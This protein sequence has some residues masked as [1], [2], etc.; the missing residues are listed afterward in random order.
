MFVSVIMCVIVRVFVY[1]CVIVRMHVIL[2]VS[3]CVWASLCESSCAC[4][5]LCFI[6]GFTVRENETENKVYKW[7]THTHTMTHT[8]WNTHYDI[9]KITHINRQLIQHKRTS[10]DQNAKTH[11]LN[12]YLIKIWISYIQNNKKLNYPNTVC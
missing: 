4:L 9:Q 6:V 8:Q 5:R 1:V 10:S 12:K 3:S 2:C 7:H 11:E